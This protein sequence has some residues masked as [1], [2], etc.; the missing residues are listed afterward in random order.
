MGNK[1]KAEI[2][3]SDPNELNPSDL[4]KYNKWTSVQ[5]LSGELEPPAKT[6]QIADAIL[7]GK[8][9]AEEDTFLELTPLIE[10]YILEKQ[11]KDEETRIA[12]NSKTVNYEN[13]V[14]LWRLIYKSANDV[15]G[16]EK[17]VLGMSMGKSGVLVLVSDTKDYKT[18]LSTEYVHD[19]TL[20]K[21][22]GKDGE[23]DKWVIK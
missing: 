17:L 10:A 21:V 20:F 8:I 5:Q 13:G 1:T 19:S 16:F 12:Y 6:S 18:V 22:I 4:K 15:L 2:L 14:N 7:E 23:D 3:S 9:T 11:A